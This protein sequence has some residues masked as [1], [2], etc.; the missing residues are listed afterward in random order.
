MVRLGWKA[1]IS[2]ALA[3]AQLVVF[4]PVAQARD[5]SL[6]SGGMAESDAFLYS[7]GSATVANLSVPLSSVIL[8]GNMAVSTLAGGAY[9][10]SPSVDIGADGT[11][12]WNY[13]GTGYGSFGEQTLL[14]DGSGSREF[15]FP[16][17]GNGTARVLLPK[18]ATV[19][20]AGFDLEGFAGQKWWNTSWRNRVPLT[21]KELAGKDQTDF[22]VETLLDTRNWTLGGAEREF[23]VTRVNNTTLDE[24]EVP[25]QVV[26]EVNNGSKCFEAALIFPVQNLS[27][28]SSQTYYLYF[29][30]PGA[31]KSPLYRDFSPRLVK[32]RLLDQSP[33]S[34]FFGPVVAPNMGSFDAAGNYYLADFARHCVFSYTT[35]IGRPGDPGSDATR[36]RGPADAVARPDGSIVV[37]DR[38]NFRVQVFN[39]DGS[40]AFTLGATGVQGTD[41]SHFISPSGAA[42]D[43][44]GNIYVTDSGAHRVQIFDVN[45]TYLA[46]IGEPGLSGVDNAHFKMP[47]GLAVSSSKDILVVDTANQ[48]LQAFKYASGAGWSWNYT[49]GETG[50]MGVNNAHF[51]GPMDVALDRSGNS[52][53][54]DMGNHRVQVFNGT[55]Y[56]ATI[57]VPGLAGPDN[58]RLN[59]PLGVAVSP[60]G[61]IFVSDTGARRVQVFDATYKY[62]QSLGNQNATQYIGPGAGNGA[63]DGPGG[64][65]VNSSG[66]IFVSDTNNH[67]VQVFGPTGGLVKT[68][69]VT[70]APGSDMSHFNLPRGLDVASNGTL[71]VADGGGAFPSIISNHRVL[72]FKNLD[73]GVADG[74]LGVTGQSANDSAHLNQPWDVSVNAGGRIAVADKGLV[75]LG[76]PVSF[77]GI[78]VQIF[79]DLQ[80]TSADYTYGVAGQPGMDPAR[81]NFPQ[82]VGETDSGWTYVADT[83]NN[84]VVLFKNDGDSLSDMVLNPSGT[85]GTGPYQLKTPT[86]VDSDSSGNIYVADTGNHRVAVYDTNGAYLYILG[87]TGVN[88]S[89]A[90]HLSNPMG[91]KLGGDDKLYIADTGNNRVVRITSA[92]LVLGAA[93]AFV[94][95][96][97]VAVDIGADKIVEWARAGFLTG[98]V[99]VSGLAPVLNSLL[100][101]LSAIPDSSGNELVSVVF[102]LSNAG[103]GRIV[104]SNLSI[105][106]NCSTAIPG[107]ASAVRAYV[108]SHAAEADGSGNVSVPIGYTAASAGGVRLGNLLLTVDAPPDLLS[109]IPDRALDEDTAQPVLYN[110]TEYIR[111]DFDTTLDFTLV[112]LTNY[113]IVDVRLVNGSVLSVDC[114]GA[115][116]RNFHGSISFLVKAVDSRG[117][118][119]LSNRVMVTIRPVNDAP[120]ITSAP[121]SFPAQ[122]GTEWSYSVGASDVDGDTLTYILEVKP[123]GMTVNASSG[124]VAWTPATGDVGLQ[125]VRL[126]ATDGALSA[127][128]NFSLNVTPADATNHRPVFTST[129]VTVAQT[130]KQY[131]YQ[132]LA[133]DDDNDPLSY[134]LDKAPAQMTIDNVTGLIGWTPQ[135]AQEGRHDVSVR[136]TDL[137][138]SVVQDFTV[139]VSANI[140]DILPTVNITSH[141]PN[142]KVGGSVWIRGTASARNGTVESVELSI[143]LDG[144]W[145]PAD[146]KTGWAY[147]LDTTK[148]SNG[149]HNIYVRARDSSGNYGQ[150]NITLDVQNTKT[151]PAAANTLFGIPL[152]LWLVLVVVIV[153]AAAASAYAFARKKRGSAPS[154]KTPQPASSTP[155]PPAVAAP[156]G[157][158]S[159]TAPAT[160][161]SPAQ[162]PTAQSP[163][164]A[165]S[166]TA[167]SA[168][169][170]AAAYPPAQSL[171]AYHPVQ[172]SAVTYAPSTVPVPPS[173]PSPPIKAVDSVFLIYHDGRLI[174]YFSRSESIK[175]DDTLDMIRK[176]VRASF[177]GQLGKLDSMRYENSN[178]IMERGNMM[179]MVV[180][181]PLTDCDRVR[182]EMRLLL[183]E[184][185]N[186]YRVVFKIWDGDFNKV[187]G[188]KT[189]IEKFS[190]EEIV[191]DQPWSQIASAAQQSPP[192]SSAP[193]A[194]QPQQS[195]QPA[196]HPFS[197]PPPYTQVVPP[198]AIPSTPL[199]PPPQTN[200]AP[201]SPPPSSPVQPSPSPPGQPYPAPGATTQNLPPPPQP[202][203]QSLPPPLPQ[204]QPRPPPLATIPPPTPAKAVSR[205]QDLVDEGELEDEEGE[206]S[207]AEQSTESAPQT[208]DTFD[209][210]PPPPGKTTMAARSETQ[211][212]HKVRGLL[213]EEDEDEE[214]PGEIEWPKEQ[215]PK[216]APVLVSKQEPTEVPP[217]PPAPTP[218]PPAPPRPAATGL[219]DS[220]RLQL[221]E[222]RFLRGEITELTYRELREKLGKK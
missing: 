169:A 152:W 125:Q 90:F 211:P 195:Y 168:P 64:V 13:D 25:V 128:Q 109:A 127:W 148:L 51:M 91:L 85:P 18:N 120:V 216:I 172:S 153:A 47:S 76:P 38:D 202:S 69:G 200:P 176:F 34:G 50:V 217:A 198:P 119:T 149:I 28:G 41:N 124:R 112:N 133:R 62:V 175:L 177:S 174:T 199:P 30:N 73:D 122:V 70:G 19:Q 4:L 143:D 2:L 164:P 93:E 129:P 116:A 26:D 107:V 40:V 115:A 118:A 101:G 170:A 145:S 36:L 165:P 196:P 48:R 193:P 80:D 60:S 162:G 16:I 55:L 150:A 72:V 66:N 187:K 87:E 203:S 110:F 214:P 45:G 220:E 35:T 166:Q 1:A 157:A 201:P 123:D 97:N 10:A 192:H 130:G 22:S 156:A 114:T 141:A 59:G 104:L 190:G 136:V 92:S 100:P 140:V 11:V 54:V 65:S 86:D 33:G 144:K 126:R 58:S 139:T 138:I 182:R 8:S 17:A 81:L 39:P 20:S 213:D 183:E 105:L 191:P 15:S 68:L 49:I 29:N 159:M 67:R 207:G 206:V 155:P 83:M 222:D 74:Q 108:E 95:P 56:K 197:S 173:N 27:A 102:N 44:E 208:S 32:S 121:P 117:L 146:G 42:T 132:V 31:V 103:T 96:E 160:A 134:S 171:A 219:T 135:A 131:S 6:F 75:I 163:A 111:D 21:V 52:Y 167:V 210:R 185:N 106:Y 71:V 212:P 53:V 137:K 113:T 23:R 188:V 205:P 204:S 84:R 46:T 89:D 179:Y 186:Q 37:T 184:I 158:Y 161:Y 9:P 88:L 78:R 12:E 151:A 94:A 147:H 63:F 24:T 5:I 79:S 181:T 154:S 61:R 99:S 57:G 14:E 82:G 43:D 215:A 98:I 7:G 3:A 194:S 142:A 77:R 180:I 221:L 209:T 218:I 178:I 189:L